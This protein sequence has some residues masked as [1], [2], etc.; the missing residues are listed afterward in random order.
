MGRETITTLFVNSMDS[1]W[2]ILFG[3]KNRHAHVVSKLNCCR[4]SQAEAI[5][6]HKI[7]S[8]I[9]YQIF[10]PTNEF[11]Y[12]VTSSHA[13]LFDSNRLSCDEATNTLKKCDKFVVKFLWLLVENWRILNFS[14]TST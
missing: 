11:T 14:Q 7:F 6:F 9:D 13:N 10:S 12:N 5:D 8:H 3:P 2:N 1:Q 4:L